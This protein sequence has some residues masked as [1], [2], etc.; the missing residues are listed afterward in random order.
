MNLLPKT[1]SAVR[2]TDLLKI[3]AQTQLIS[4]EECG[5]HDVADIGGSGLV[6]AGNCGV[7]HFL[8]AYG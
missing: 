1:S 5:R 6:R 7:Y 3:F 2:V 8:Y 4:E